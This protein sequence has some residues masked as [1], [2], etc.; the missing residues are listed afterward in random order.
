MRLL[1]FP[2]L[3]FLF[4]TPTQ[5]SVHIA[6]IMYNPTGTDA[7]NEWIRIEINEEEL[8]AS[9][10]I[11]HEAGTSHKITIM[12]GKELFNGTAFIADDGQSFLTSYPNVTATILDSAFSL[13]NSGERIAISSGNLTL[14]NVTYDNELANGNGKSLHR[15]ND[16]WVEEQPSP[17]L[18]SESNSTLH[19][20]T[21]NSS[22][23][24]SIRFNEQPRL[25]T[26][27]TYTSLWLITN[28]NHQSGSTQNISALI[29]TTARVNDTV[30]FEEMISITALNLKKSS[31]TSNFTPLAP[32]NITLCSQIISSSI[33]DEET[34][35]NVICQDIEIIESSEI[36]CNI[37]LTI[38]KDK[39]LYREGESA[40]FWFEL[41]NESFPYTITYEITDIFGNQKRTS[42]TTTNKNKK[43]FTPTLTQSQEIYA[44][45]ATISS[46]AC[47]N[48]NS[49]IN[50]GAYLLFAGLPKQTTSAI[51]IS[52]PSADSIANFGDIVRTNINVYKGNSTKSVLK[53]YVETNDGKVAT[54]LQTQL[55]L[56]Q[57]FT[58]YEL[59]VP[60]QIKR[61]CNADLADGEYKIIAE[62]FDTQAQAK[63][64]LQGIPKDCAQAAT[65]VNEQASSTR[66]I[67]KTITQRSPLVYYTL[68][69]P[70]EKFLSSEPIQAKIKIHNDD[71]FP[72]S[73]SVWS[74]VYNGP[75]SY[76]GEREGNKRDIEVIPNS[77]TEIDIQTTASVPKAGEYKLKINILR[78]ETKT[79][80]SFTSSVMIEPDLTT[81]TKSE[82]VYPE[83]GED[84]ELTLQNKT[85][86]TLSNKA[87]TK[88]YQSPKFLSQ[89]RV[90]AILMTV[91]LAL[92]L[93]FIVNPPN[94]KKG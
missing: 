7:K 34:E 65:S 3:I 71:S 77:M 48:T 32:S 14:D 23:D 49:P 68:E 22:A 37:S 26:K 10:L 86:K 2:F 61:N 43:S 29:N 64:R 18:R 6:E 9:S 67:T 88:L 79:P 13:S 47:N 91:A 85:Q 82:E 70:K 15:S 45:N 17:Q 72:H 42:Q 93:G 73:F 1:Y 19:N 81:K 11:L 58:D 56:D 38:H 62:G 57:K 60:L 80:K 16:S 54:Q 46:I 21:L 78:D 84:S 27:R 33:P 76:S 94:Q 35:N 90:P 75:V 30:Y 52:P 40:K 87:E 89:K 55:T 63:I 24:L 25:F 66:T 83:L 4:A 5:A 28:E 39:E 20:S 44:I 51:S 59:A 36:P 69:P 8:N 12:R 41:N 53:V 74:Y 92:C 50:K 31:G